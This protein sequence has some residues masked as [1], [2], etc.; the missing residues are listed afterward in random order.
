MATVRITDTLNRDIRRKLTSIYY[1]RVERVKL[2][3]LTPENNQAIY[4]T[5][6]G[7]YL[8][9]IEQSGLPQALFRKALVLDIFC[10][11]T[12][13]RT[14]LANKQIFWENADDILPFVDSSS[15]GY[16]SGEINI[17]IK[18]EHNYTGTPLQLLVDAA[19]KISEINNEEKEA[20][21]AVHALLT[22]YS[23]LAPALKEWPALWDLLEDDV[24][25]KHKEVAE[26][27]KKEPKPEVTDTPDFSSLTAAVIANKLGA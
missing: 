20:L 26:R 23:T 5:F 19:A 17:T 12:R 4:N 10:N 21:K 16:S 22:K 18:P 13:F 15:W 8:G 27:K 2:A 3:V 7:D 6:I 11:G 9:A 1:K 24:K 25:A 14:D